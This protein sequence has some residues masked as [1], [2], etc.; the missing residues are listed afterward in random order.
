MS[1][2]KLSNTTATEHIQSLFYFSISTGFISQVW[3]IDF[4]L[5]YSY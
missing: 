1:D 4:F 3:A 2:I 5:L